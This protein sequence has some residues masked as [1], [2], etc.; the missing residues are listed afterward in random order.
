MN[1][2]VLPEANIAKKSRFSLIWLIPLLAALIGSWLAFKYY[3]EKGTMIVVNFEQATG[4]EANKTPVRYKDVEVGMVKKV[5]LSPDLNTVRVEV[6]IYPDMEN[7]LGPDTRF[8]TVTPR[9]TLRGVSGLE[10]LLSGVNIGMEPGPGGNAKSEYAG[11]SRQPS[12]DIQSAGQ[13]IVLN[14]ERLGSLDIGSPVYYRQIQVGEVTDYKLNTN[15]QKVDIDVFIFAPYDEK[16]R[17]NSRFWNASGFELDIS[18]LGVTARLE[19]LT[20][21]LIGGIAFETNFDEVGYP[22]SGKSAFRLYDGFKRAHQDTASE[23]KLLYTLYFDDTLHGLSEGSDVKYRGIK[24]GQVEKI[25][26]TRGSENTTIRTQVKVAMYVDRLSSTGSRLEAE[27]LL[28]ALVES[29]IRA[30]LTTDSIVTGAQFISMVTDTSQ[31]NYQTLARLGGNHDVIFPNIPAKTSLLNFDP[32][33]VTNE[34]NKA[35]GT[36]NSLLSSGDVKKSLNH[37]S[38]TMRSIDT[39][40]AELSRQGISGEVMDLLKE[41]NKT[42]NGL[43]L[44]LADARKVMGTVD[45]VA[46]NLEKSANKAL[47]DARVMMQSAGKAAASLSGSA[48]VLQKD[49]S[50]AMIDARVMMQSAGK[51][52]TSLSGSANVL[53]KDASKAMIDARVMMQSAGK[54]AT[55]LT[56]TANVLQKDASKAMIDARVMMQSASKAATSLSGSAD[57]LQK[58]ASKAMIDARVMMQSAGKAATSLSGSADVLQ[59]DASKAMIDARVM[60]QNAGKAATALTDTANVLQKDA[61]KAIIDARVM[62]QKAGKAATAFTGTANV[63]QKDASKAMIDARIMMQKAGKSVTVL[64]KDASKAMIDGR[65][66]MQKVGKTTETLGKDTT[67]TLWHINKA[68]LALEKGI[69]STMNEDSALQY[70]F[71]QLINDLSEAASSFSVLADTLQR[72]PN[73][74]ILGK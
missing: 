51:A 31:Q 22:I 53:Q 52:A 7:N 4:I 47:I 54:A 55:A 11:L 43:T 64:Q 66:M 33:S 63:L 46:L 56:G 60:M 29:G 23:N 3:T 48:S 9:I 57:V 26:L 6:E 61:S 42:A 39:V 50:K 49:A 38:S 21:L 15:N 71:Q 70:H 17:T 40:T 13:S 24:M 73:A 32:S 35:I 36:A 8:W 58:D 65:V 62:M 27:K 28:R 14:A 44:A 5:G 59:K 20:S 37:L 45:G 30:Q 34:L 68:S 41:A 2:Y 10:T 69:N 72:K 25:S 19:S 18:T 16:I 67:R 74:L 1:E 12:V